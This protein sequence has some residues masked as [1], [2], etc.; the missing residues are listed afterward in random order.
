MTSPI[1]HP[2]GAKVIRFQ[3]GVSVGNFSGI[4]SGR[5]CDPR[6]FRA[7]FPCKWQGFLRAHFQSHLHAAVFFSVEEK[8]ARLWWEGT[9]APQGWAVD[10]AIQSIPSAASWLRAA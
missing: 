7:Q 1:L 5:P 10:Y 8:T 2:S 9:N 4:L 6:E 3:A